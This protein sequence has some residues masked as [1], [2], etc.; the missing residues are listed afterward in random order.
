[1]LIYVNQL[2][3]VGEDA[4]DKAVAS[5]GGWLK[6]LTNRHFS[7]SELKKSENYVIGRQKV[8]TYSAV[9]KNPHMYSILFSNPDRDV[10]GRQ[11]ITEIGLLAV[12]GGVLFSLLLETSD[13]ST[14]VKSIPNSTRPMVIDYIRKNC[15]LHHGIVGRE[16][17]KI[18]N[19]EDDFRSLLADIERPERDYPLVLVS[20]DFD[21]GQ[22]RVN[23]VR[24]QEQLLGLAQVVYCDNTI[25]SWDMEDVLTRRYAAWG[26]A[27]N[28]IF[29]I[30]NKTQC[31]RKLFTY[32]DL[33]D[34]T[35][36]GRKIIPEILSAVTHT[37]NGRGKKAHFSPTDVRAR[38]QKDHSDYLKEKIQKGVQSNGDYFSLFEDAM[39]QIEDY[40][41]VIDGLK[42]DCEKTITDIELSKMGLEDDIEALREE[43]WKATSKADSILNTKN[44]SEGYLS[45]EEVFQ[46]IYDS[47][48]GELGP[49]Q[50]LKIISQIFKDRIV[51]LDSAYQSARDSKRFKHNKKLFLLMY[52]LATEYVEAVSSGGDLKALN[53]FGSSYTANESESVIKSPELSKLRTF[54]Y[55]NESIK[56]FRHLKIGAADN[57]E[58]TIRV[59]FHWDSIEKKIIIGYCGP[60]LPIASKNH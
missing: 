5:V 56:M 57:V 2:H 40:E 8:R 59:H 28:L 50:L 11:W 19:S 52:K 60:H 38:R 55:K 20:C 53:I 1:M 15:A 46:L 27:I 10:S 16:H 37:T 25:D 39:K 33:L 34:L 24:L 32:D 7:I 45:Q 51:I 9:Y 13:I 31:A 42:E 30:G 6:K 18:S 43:L 54:L 35:D 12:E 47:L 48:L 26:G 22:P 21:C 29:P 17:K 4:L 36:A 44:S 41:M 14:Q 3:L 23:I 58:Q 49:E